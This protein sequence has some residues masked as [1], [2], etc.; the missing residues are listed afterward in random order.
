MVAVLE[1]LWCVKSYP[2][3]DPCCTLAELNLEAV[4]HEG[5]LASGPPNAV[6]KKGADERRDEIA[7]Q[8]WVQ[9]QQVLESRAE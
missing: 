5:E 4:E 3:C 8:I 2:W 7:E 9:Y 6:E 1:Q